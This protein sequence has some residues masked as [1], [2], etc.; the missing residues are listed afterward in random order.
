MTFAIITTLECSYL[1]YLCEYGAVSVSKIQLSR[2]GF[3]SEIGEFFSPVGYL[4]IDNLGS[5]CITYKITVVFLVFNILFL[6]VI[7]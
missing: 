1:C 4:V 6:N 5:Y 3:F 7:T 2:L